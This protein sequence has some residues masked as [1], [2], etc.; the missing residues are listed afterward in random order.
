MKRINWEHP[1]SQVIE[2]PLP[3]PKSLCGRRTLV[4]WRHNHIFSAWWVTNIP[5]QWWFAGGLRAL[6]LRYNVKE[7]K[8]Q[9]IAQQEKV[10]IWHNSMCVDVVQRNSFVKFNAWANLLK[11]PGYPGS[12]HQ[13]FIWAC[14]HSQTPKWGEEVWLG[15]KGADLYARGPST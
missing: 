11:W 7:G 5:Y 8:T 12:L 15:S 2:T 1:K 10:S 4:Q 14:V 9:V 13:N 6:K 3:L